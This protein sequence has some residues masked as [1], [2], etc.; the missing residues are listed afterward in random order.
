MSIASRREA[1]RPLFIASLLLSLSACGGGGGSSTSG[2][3]GG[4]NSF[5][6]V[7]N[8]STAQALLATS[9]AVELAQ[10]AGD[11]VFSITQ[12]GR[13]YETALPPKNYA[14]TQHGAVSGTV[15][16]SGTIAA[17]G[18]GT[19]T[20]TYTDYASTAGSVYNGQ[21]IVNQSASTDSV[22]TLTFSDYSQQTN[23]GTFDYS[24]TITYDFNSTSGQLVANLL[25]T[26]GSF[27]VKMSNLTV[28]I[29][30][31]LAFVTASGRIYLA[32]Q[33]YV[34]VSTPSTVWYG[35]GNDV[36]GSALDVFPAVGAGELVLA[37]S[38]GAK[39]HVQPLS[40]YLAYIGLDTTGNGTIDIGARVDRSTAEL[41]AVQPTGTSVQAM[42]QLPNAVTAT[43]P[44]T[45]DGRGSYTPSGWVS[46]AWKL[47]LAPPGSS[48]SLS[49]NGPTA[50][51]TPDVPGSYIVELT[52][53]AAGKSDIDTITVNAFDTPASTAP[54]IG[55]SPWTSFKVPGHINGAIG[56]PVNLDARLSV[57]ARNIP[58]TGNSWVLHTPPGSSATLAD[59][60]AVQTSFTPDVAGIY[61]VTVGPVT[62]SPP[63]S[64]FAPSN[65][66]V[67]GVDEPFRFAAPAMLST[68]ATA[69][70]FLTGVF[71]SGAAPAYGFVEGS[72][73]TFPNGYVSITQPLGNGL[74]SAPTGIGMA[75]GITGP[76]RMVTA[77][78]D[79]DGLND[80]IAPAGCKVDFQESTAAYAATGVSVDSSCTSSN[81]T[82]LQAGTIGGKPAVVAMDPNYSG[83]GKQAFAAYIAGASGS[84]QTPVYTALTVSGSID[85]IVSLELADMDG[86]GEDDLIALVDNSGT[87]AS[88]AIQIYHGNGD[89]TFTFVSNTPLTGSPGNVPMAI[90]DFNG[91][92][93]M[94]VAVVYNTTLN[95]LY[96]DG[97][98]N[99]SSTDTRAMVCGSITLFATDLNQDGHLDLVVGDNNGSACPA[100]AG[101]YTAMGMFLSDSSGTL[102][103]EQFYPV[104]TDGHDG[105]NLGLL[106]HGGLMDLEGD[107]LQGMLFSTGYG[108]AI[109]PQIPGVTSAST[110]TSL[111][112]SRVE[113]VAAPAQPKPV[114][115]LWVKPLASTRP[116]P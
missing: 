54:L 90:G 37:G 107:G 97:H 27:Q 42:V 110:T 33:G 57:D 73:T 116:D 36:T 16:T 80:L 20:Q 69:P 89:G 41:D 3:G 58:D 15:V 65:M 51:F 76:T 59:P 87:Q 109:M 13:P 1:V 106:T 60:T 14:S 11:A 96:G 5:P 38:G 63:N 44:V 19:V 43:S 101:G 53:T 82:V 115:H 56:T 64:Y 24:G 103:Q 75:S 32:D 9:N 34:D 114:R 21:F 86:D 104:V 78:L 35:S 71:T 2:G 28:G 46:Y 29:N 26:S 31:T 108:F 18:S 91:D 74:F 17:D 66:V 93:K 7:Y 67:I 48:L 112:T 62:N 94:D 105:S 6:T 72:T 10:Q 83:T 61:Y 81:V 68:D 84:M 98:G 111:L 70:T 45:V 23:D 12:T 92:G 99:I 85:N 30:P 113:A 22:G 50:G 4:N 88:A 55:G 39:L 25:I 95:L 100:H 8:G 77:D 102:S 52:A 79:G 47:L 40:D 49:G